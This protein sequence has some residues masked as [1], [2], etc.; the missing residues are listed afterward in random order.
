MDF[1]FEEQKNPSTGEVEQ[2]ASCTG[3]L[4]SIS[5]EAKKNVNGTEFRNA[6]VQIETADGTA[7]PF[8]AIV[9]ENNFKHGM[10]VGGSYLTRITVGADNSVLISMSHLTSANSADVADFGLTPSTAKADLEK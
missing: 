2:V 8:N 4:V 6:T 10:E 7:K 1:K 9:Y 5:A 3:K